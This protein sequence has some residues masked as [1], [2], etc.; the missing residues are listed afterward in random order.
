M[1]FS[2]AAVSCGEPPVVE[3]AMI[4]DFTGVMYG[5]KVTYKCAGDSA[6]A[7]YDHVIC[8]SNGTWTEPPTCS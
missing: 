5:D 7:G 2:I 6:M 4:D 8:Q 3:S 1:H